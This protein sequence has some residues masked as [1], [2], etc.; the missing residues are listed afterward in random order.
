MGE[1]QDTNVS[2]GEIFKNHWKTF[3]G[4]FFLWLVFF[5]G[6]VWIGN[7]L[8]FDIFN[9]SMKLS[10]LGT[11][12]DSFNVLTSLFTG[13]AFAGVV[14]SII[15][16]TQELKA[17][18]DELQGQKEAL[19]K[20]QKEMMIQSFDNKFFQML[21]N[22]N[23]IINS[24]EIQESTNKISQ[25]GERQKVS[26]TGKAVFDFFL[27]EKISYFSSEED[28]EKIFNVEDFQKK[29]MKFSFNYSHIIET[30]FLN[31]YQILK[32]IDK[33]KNH[34]NAKDYTNIIRAQLSSSE[35]IFLFYNGIGVINQHGEKYKELIENYSL[36]EHMKIIDIFDDNKKEEKELFF[37][38]LLEYQEVA[39]GNNEGFI[40]IREILKKEN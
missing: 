17:T 39:F 23:N 15:L 20:Q 2:I 29:Y 35:K 40:R 26:L 5:I 1:R 4:V 36:L 21:D 14:I 9:P 22:F 3:M 12:G 38:I 33:H 25:Y 24:F 31:L 13:L 19:E 30:Y 16:Q 11:F 10:D 37:K 7:D 8:S 34:I 6:T 28:P 32:Y 27:L 18:R